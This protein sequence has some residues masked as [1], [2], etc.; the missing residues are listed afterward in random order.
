MKL[1]FKK[2]LVNTLALLMVMLPLSNALAMQLDQASNH[3]EMDAESMAVMVMDHA[4]HSLISADAIDDEVETIASNCTCCNQCDGECAG[5]IHISSAIA[6]DLLA[7]SE[8]QKNELVSIMTD[9]LLTRTISPP[10]R[11]PLIL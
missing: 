8:T 11:P 4:N 7:F 3:C 9:L 10:S 6:F 1:L 2:I 5:C